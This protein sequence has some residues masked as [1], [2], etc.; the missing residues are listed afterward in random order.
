MVDI[1]VD[2]EVRD[3]VWCE[4]GWLLDEDTVDDWIRFF[5][6]DEELCSK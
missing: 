5:L 1:E 3:E 2:K 6:S 4:E